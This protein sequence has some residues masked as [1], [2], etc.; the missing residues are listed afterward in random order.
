MPLFK[1]TE[2]SAH[3]DTLWTRTTTPK[4]FCDPEYLWNRL[5]NKFN[6]ITIPIFD[7]SAFL[8]EALEAA[9]LEDLME[10]RFH[11][12][13][14]DY[15]LRLRQIAYRLGKWRDTLSSATSRAVASQLCETGCLDDFMHFVG[16]VALGWPEE[17]TDEQL[18]TYE[19]E[20]WQPHL[21]GHC[22]Y[23]PYLHQ[24][25]IDDSE[26]EFLAEAEDNAKRSDHCK[27]PSDAGLDS[28][29][30]R[31]WTQSDDGELECP[32]PVSAPRQEASAGGSGH[33]IE[34]AQPG[35]STESDGAQFLE[36][37]KVTLHDMPNGRS[38][39][40]PAPTLNNSD[41]TTTQLQ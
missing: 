6:T 29:H 11:F 14:R 32:S 26:T 9:E 27:S 34:A 25:Q 35:L 18:R 1:Q 40:S 37:S 24:T 31:I 7:D 10:K 5:Y 33:L 12:H 2:R 21:F 30:P 38:T 17:A 20:H 13:R 22:D 28:T 23:D 36:P 19:D 16:G 4:D 39:V 3:R 8:A 15:I 41:A